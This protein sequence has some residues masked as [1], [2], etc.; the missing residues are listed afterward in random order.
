MYKYS[1]NPMY[2]GSPRIENLPDNPENNV[3][4][5]NNNAIKHLKETISD[6]VA[7]EFWSK[8]QGLKGM[9]TRYRKMI[10]ELE[11]MIIFF[12]GDAW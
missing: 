11:D 7:S 4:K 2:E 5:A 12:T 3:L 10:A 6:L 8:K 9:A 1:G